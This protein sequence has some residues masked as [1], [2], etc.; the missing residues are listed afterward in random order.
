M[1]KN[2]AVAAVGVLL[3]CGCKKSENPVE[4][5]PS[6]D[7]GILVLNSGNIHSN[8]AGVVSY[9]WKT[10]AVS[11]ELFLKA[12]G[13]RMGD[14]VNDFLAYGSKLY[15]AVTNSAVLFVTDRNCRILKEIICEGQ[16]GVHYS[17]RCLCCAGGKV[18]V[19]WQEG[20]LSEMDTASYALRTVKVGDNP[21]GVAVTGGKI[22]VANSFGFD[23]KMEYGT[24]VSVLD[25][26]S[27][28]VSGTLS[29]HNNPQTFTLT[30]DGKL[31]LVCFGNFKDIPAV[32]QR[33]NI[34]SQTVT[35]IIDVAPQR[36]CDGPDG[37]AYLI[38][39][40]KG[41]VR[42]VRFNTRTNRVDGELLPAASVPDG[43]S[44]SYDDKSGYVFIGTSDY[45]T[46]GEVYVV[47]QDGQ[48]LTHFDTGGLNPIK[49]LSRY[50]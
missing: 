11:E 40:E 33:I 27:F 12:N 10:G 39:G 38:A 6:A 30:S 3:L 1:K 31:Y 13:R 44:I 16:G 7:G 50:E 43:Y 49:V 41:A 15:F 21:E 23:P 46:N 2:V 18:Y 48:I 34:E 25:A 47:S 42:Y 24:T 36:M 5:K 45:R 22:Y 4:P 26:A 19:T 17:P 20:Y 37:T 8:D 28:M 14:V 29:V 32:L 35:N 9:D